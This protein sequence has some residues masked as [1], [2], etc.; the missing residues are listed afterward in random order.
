MYQIPLTNQYIIY[1]YGSFSI[2]I[3]L[4]IHAHGSLDGKSLWLDVFYYFLRMVIAFVSIL[5]VT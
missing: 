5:R 1:V 2:N 4:Y 3:C